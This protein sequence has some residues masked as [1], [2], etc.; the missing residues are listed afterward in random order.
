[1]GR[2]DIVP[3][4]RCGPTLAPSASAWGCADLLRGRRSHS[5]RRDLFGPPRRREAAV[6]RTEGKGGAGP[7]NTTRT[8]EREVG[9]RVGQ[10]SSLRVI[11][12]EKGG[13]S[14]R[15]TPFA[16]GPSCC[17]SERERCPPEAQAAGGSPV[18]RVE[19]QFPAGPGSRGVGGGPPAAAI[20]EGA[21]LVIEVRG[22]IT[23]RPRWFV[24]LPP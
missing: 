16:P 21:A 2:V 13:S 5:F 3:E 24:G 6:K 7:V 11:A 23:S 19:A 9:H 18:G 12:G 20:S 1:M 17:F 10:R 8:V 4:P 22:T 14:S 15:E